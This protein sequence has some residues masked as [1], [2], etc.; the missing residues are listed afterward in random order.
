VHCCRR[1]RLALD[2]I[3]AV[4]FDWIAYGIAALVTS[5]AVVGAPHDPAGAAATAADA[6][7]TAAAA[8]T[9]AAGTAAAAKGV[10]LLSS[11]RAAMGVAGS[12]HAA[13]LS[14]AAGNAM[15][16]AGSTSLSSL[17]PAIACLKGLHLVGSQ[18]LGAVCMFAAAGLEVAKPCACNWLQ[19]G[20][21]VR[22]GL[23]LD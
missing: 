18:K 10:G 23:P 12:T 19:L 20:G 4:P 7:A 21:C 15:Q 9:A 22:L 2:V 14:A 8:G 16:A 5:A 11:A 1:Q 6:A 17:V 3:S 13:A